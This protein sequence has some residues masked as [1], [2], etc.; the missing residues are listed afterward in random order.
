M[1]RAHPFVFLVS[2]V[3][4]KA[5]LK[6]LLEIKKKLDHDEQYYY[7]NKLYIDDYCIWIQTH[8]KDRTLR[9]LAHELHKLKVQKEETGFP[10]ADLEKLAEEHKDDFEMMEE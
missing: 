7:L 2:R 3:G 6:C 5:V 1:R 10:L 8:A 4:R 9:N